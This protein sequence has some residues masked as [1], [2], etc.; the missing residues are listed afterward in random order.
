[1]T[2]VHIITI[3]GGNTHEAWADGRQIGDAHW[4]PFK[5]V[6]H[7]AVPAA[8]GPIVTVSALAPVKDELRRI[9]NEALAKDTAR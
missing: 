6:W 2:G 8:D 7:I 5:N 9:A 1:M 3:P 4:M